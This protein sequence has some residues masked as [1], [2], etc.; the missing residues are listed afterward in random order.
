M[1]LAFL[2]NMLHIGPHIGPAKAVDRLLGIANADQTPVVTAGK[3]PV[4]KLPLLTV[5]V[6]GLVHDRERETILEGGQ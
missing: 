4:K 2:L 1:G 6:L 3:E 5:G